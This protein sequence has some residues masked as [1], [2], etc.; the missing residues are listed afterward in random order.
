MYY[1]ASVNVVLSAVVPVGVFAATVVK[2][3]PEAVMKNPSIL[4]LD[5]YYPEFLK[6]APLVGLGSYEAERD[7]LL[8]R[9]FGTY[10]CYSRGLTTLGW[11]CEDVIVNHKQL[12]ALTTN[13]RPKPDVVFYQDLNLTRIAPVGPVIAGQLS[14]SW[15]GDDIVRRFDILFTSFPHYVDRIEALGVRAVYVPLAFDPVV[16]ERLPLIGGKPDVKRTIDCVFVGGLG[17]QWNHKSLLDVVQGEIGHFRICGYGNRNYVPVWGLE[18]YQLYAGTKIVLNRHHPAAQGY[19]NN[20]R[21]F[22]ATGMGALLL[23]EDSPNIRDFFIPGEECV[24]YTSPSDAVDKIRYYLEHNDER[25]LIAERGKLK[26]LL[27]HTYLAHNRLPVVDRE[28]RA[29][30]ES[31]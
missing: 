13:I 8:R 28:L 30:L 23:T 6:S 24:T 16:Y 27:A 29:L 14:C 26:T 9:C 10:D 21:M 4:I 1:Y 5:T 25:E 3:Y 11:E 17:D 15:P 2:Q 12:N 22:E 19:S 31:K 20:L 7:A 18:M